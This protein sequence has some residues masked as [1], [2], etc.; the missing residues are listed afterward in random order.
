MYVSAMI[1]KINSAGMSQNPFGSVVQ[2]W[3]IISKL[4][5]PRSQS[6]MRVQRIG[7]SIVCFAAHYWLLAVNKGIYYI[8]IIQGSYSHIAY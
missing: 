1:L 7:S 4:A 8:G 6:E 5:N 2:S 3:C